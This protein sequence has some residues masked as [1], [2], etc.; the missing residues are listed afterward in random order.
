VS[1]AR[2]SVYSYIRG[3][4]KAGSLASWTY[5]QTLGKA[6]T[7]CKGQTLASLFRASM[8]KKKKYQHRHQ[9]SK[10]IEKFAAR[11]DDFIAQDPEHTKAEADE[12]PKAAEAA[13]RRESIGPECISL[14]PML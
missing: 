13:E 3:R 6:M 12:E 10:T 11:L 8:T 2:L 9:V 7:A 4:D 1:L 14:V 5:L